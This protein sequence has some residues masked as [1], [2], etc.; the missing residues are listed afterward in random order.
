MKTI[1]ALIITLSLLPAQEK[2]TPVPNAIS[3]YWKTLSPGEKEIFLFSYL[4]Q[5]FDTH[6][7]LIKD[8][9]YGELTTWYY[10]NKAE[11]IYGIFDH[12][13]Q[14]EMQAY[15]GWIDEYYSNKEFS[16]HSFDD[17]LSF[18]YRFHKAAGATIW[19]KYENLQF[20]TIKPEN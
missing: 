2:K 14:D 3:V 8:R 17:A 16:G 1:L 5:V 15:I 6:Q 10:D 4:T 9:G 11:L 7:K 18:A 12:I 20:E 13:A 19:E